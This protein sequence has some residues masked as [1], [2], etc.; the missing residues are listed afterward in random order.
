MPNFNSYFN[1][2]SKECE[3]LKPQSRLSILIFTLISILKHFFVYLNI[4]IFLLIF[5]YSVKLL[6]LPLVRKYV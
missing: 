6:F 5:T 3:R 2:I 4:F 1:D